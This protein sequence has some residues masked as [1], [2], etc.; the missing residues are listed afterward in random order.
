MLFRLV[1][2]A[3]ISF[4]ACNITIHLS[5]QKRTAIMSHSSSLPPK[6]R[7]IDMENFEIPDPVMPSPEARYAF[8]KQQLTSS[9]S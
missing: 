3:D 2:Y 1:G 6:M 4:S 7:L 8:A 5:P 9:L